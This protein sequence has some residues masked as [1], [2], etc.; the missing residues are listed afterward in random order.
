VIQK[1]AGSGSTLFLVLMTA[2]DGWRGEMTPAGIVSIVGGL[3]ALLS[4]AVVGEARN[5]Q[6]HSMARDGVPV[7]NHRDE[8]AV[9]GLD[10]AAESG[11][12]L[13]MREHLEAIH[14]IVAALSRQDFEH[15]AKIAQD[16]LGFSKHHEAMKREAGAIFPR[17][18][19]ELAMAHHQEAENLAK[20]VPSKNFKTILPQLEKT[21]GACVAC[22][23]AYKL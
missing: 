18:Y 7:E 2:I 4:L 23:Q 17:K 3:A 10:P 13:T 5:H 22:H 1:R 11:L 20:V 8:R 6:E 15:A 9:L 16:E 21:I 19:H 14:D 12:K